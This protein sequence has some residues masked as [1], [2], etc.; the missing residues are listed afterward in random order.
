MSGE[1]EGGAG[2]AG[3][4]GGVFEDVGRDFIVVDEGLAG[5]GAEGLHAVAL[6][7]GAGGGDGLEV[8]AAAGGDSEEGAAMIEAVGA[9]HGAGDDGAERMKLVQ[10]EGGEVV[11]G[12]R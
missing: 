8:E 11:V 4:E 9:E 1:A 6:V 5:V 2:P 7:V 12:H 3:E 10:H